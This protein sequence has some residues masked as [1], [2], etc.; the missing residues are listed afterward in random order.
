MSSG[1][2]TDITYNANIWNIFGIAVDNSGNVYVTTGQT[3]HILKLSSGSNSWV[4]IDGTNNFNRPEGICTDSSGNVYVT[5][6]I[7]NKIGKLPAG[8]STWV[9]ITGSG[10]FNYPTGISIDGNNNLYVANDGS[11]EV[12]V[13]TNG[14][15]TWTDATTSN[16]PDV[17]GAAVD[18]SGNLY[19]TED[20]TAMMGLF[21]WSVG[22]ETVSS[23]NNSVSSNSSS[24]TAGN[25][26][27]LTAVGDRQSATGNVVGD[28]RYIPTTWTSS[29]TGKSGT[30]T[31][32]SGNY[33][34]DYTTI[35]SRKL[36]YNSNIPKADM[37]WNTME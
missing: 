21:K 9:D 15:G 30:F 24:I 23:E 4:S 14:S 18:S 11:G 33:T 2:W 20:S 35:N 8:S 36:Y 22:A 32:N 16:L 27:T 28:E 12:K 1:T 34:S 29:E 25:P 5:D 19:A 13:L 10:T 3:P 26:V 7:A 31:L 17:W 37:G 6:A